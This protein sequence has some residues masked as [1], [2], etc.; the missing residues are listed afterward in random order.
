MQHLAQA[1]D[2]A[3]AGVTLHIALKVRRSGPPA[4]GGGDGGRV[5]GTTLG[6]DGVGLLDVIARSHIDLHVDRLHLQTVN[7]LDVIG[8]DIITL[9]DFRRAIEPG[10]IQ[11]L[12]VP[13]MLMRVDDQLVCPPSRC[14]A[15]RCGESCGGGGVEKLAAVHGAGLYVMETAQLSGSGIEVL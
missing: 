6:Y 8:G 13:E 2:D 5:A 7:G 1:F 4:N 14:G 12:A 3:I 11:L 10:Q 15:G 9:Q